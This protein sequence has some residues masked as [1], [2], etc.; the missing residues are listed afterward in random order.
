M[1]VKEL[2]SKFYSVPYDF[3]VMECAKFM[4]EKRTAS[5]LVKKENDF[6]GVITER[7]ILRK[8]VAKGLDAS[9][10]FVHEI[11]SSPIITISQDAPIEEATAIMEEKDIRR[12]AVVDGN[13]KIIGKITSKRIAKNFSNILARKLRLRKAYRDAVV[14]K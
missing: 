5:V 3:T 13:G 4:N 11:M 8:I 12:V 1:K 2:L 14:Y 7:D 9:K 10:T 6:V